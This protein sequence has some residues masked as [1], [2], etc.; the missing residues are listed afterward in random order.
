M[1]KESESWLKK[2][3]HD[4]DTAIYNLQGK[5]LDA[6]AFYCQQAVEK[7]LKALYIQEYRELVRTHDL[8]FMGKKLKIP[9][10]LLKICDEVNPFY[11]ETRYP[12]V[13]EEYTERDVSEAVM[14]AKRV[15]EWVK[16]RI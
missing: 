4:F 7:A 9:E 8:V 15:I 2:S 16:E 11:V 12:D 3:D 13:Y 5:R 10:D 1:K 14:K 6:A